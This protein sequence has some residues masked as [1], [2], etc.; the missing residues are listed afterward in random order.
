[1]SK[2]ILLKL[3]KDLEAVKFGEFTLSSGKKSNMYVDARK[4]LLT[5]DGLELVCDEFLDII[6]DL[7]VKSNDD[8]LFDIDTVGGLETGANVIVGGMLKTFCNYGFIWKK[9]IKNYG[10]KQRFEG[11]LNENSKIILVDDVATSGSSFIQVI[12]GIKGLYPKAKINAAFVVVDRQEGA[13][14]LLKSYNIPLYS[15]LTKQDLIDNQ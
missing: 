1:M 10:T 6:C 7:E 2:K 4:V 13:E 15:I 3:F 12:E 11:I 9:N 8:I 14:E 5:A